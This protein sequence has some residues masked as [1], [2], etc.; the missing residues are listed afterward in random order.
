MNRNF[1]NTI[2]A[3]TG[4]AGVVVTVG[5]CEAEGTVAAGAADTVPSEGW[6][7]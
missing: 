7:G 4:R 1:I 6:D 2:K 5:V 3:G